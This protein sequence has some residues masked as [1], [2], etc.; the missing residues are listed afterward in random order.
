MSQ[1]L[2]FKPLYMYRGLFCLFLCHVNVSCDC[3][4]ILSY[5]QPL[6]DV[7]SFPDSQ[8]TKGTH[9]T[10]QSLSYSSMGSVAFHENSVS[11]SLTPKHGYYSHHM[12]LI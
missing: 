11:Y 10:G 12:I 7:D 5:N 3:S 6:I 8:V 1:F 2:C 4:L 9:A